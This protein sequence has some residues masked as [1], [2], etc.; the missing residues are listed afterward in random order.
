MPT[1]AFYQFMREFYSAGRALLDFVNATSAPVEFAD[2]P[3]GAA[4]QTVFV[5]D[6]RKNG[7]GPAAGTGV[8]AFYDGTAWVAVDTGTPVAA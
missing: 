7:E 5:S 6:G 2:L 4:G 1:D 3:T 8:M